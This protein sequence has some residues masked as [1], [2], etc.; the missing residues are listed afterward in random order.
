M[1]RQGRINIE[2]GIYHVIQ[3]GIERKA[4]FRDD[5]DREEFIG[6]LAEGLKETGHKCYGWVLM[7]N[8]FHLLIRTGVKP[9]SD[10]MRKLLT[11]YAL[12]FNRRY[13]RNGYLY[14][15]RFKSVLCQEENYLLELVRYVHLNPLRAKIVRDFKDPNEY[16]WSGHSVLMG[17]NKAEWQDTGEILERFGNKRKEAIRKYGEFVNDAK[18]MGR[19]EELTGGGLVRSVGGWKELLSLRKSDQKWLGDE[20]ILGDSDFVNT[21]LKESEEE[22]ITKE[23]LKREGWDIIKLERRACELL[24][25]TEEDIRRHSKQEEQNIPGEKFGYVLGIQQAWY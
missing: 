16:R 10:L 18:D 7:P 15:N 14:Q 20:R 13:K 8:H 25:V 5:R 22:L 3:R 21:I 23:R 17:K 1:P 24:S 19:R 11:G 9:L 2:G 4:I 6:R 12:Y